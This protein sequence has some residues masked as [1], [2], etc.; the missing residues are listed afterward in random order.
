MAVDPALAFSKNLIESYIRFKLA[1]RQYDLFERREKR[2]S[3][4]LQANQRFKQEGRRIETEQFQQ[5]F[6]QRERLARTT[7]APVFSPGQLEGTSQTSGID[8]VVRSELANIPVERSDWLGWG[9]GT[10]RIKASD[11]KKAK[12]N[13]ERT[14]GITMGGEGK[15][16][17]IEFQYQR[18]LDAIL[19][20]EGGKRTVEIIEEQ[21]AFPSRQSEEDLSQLSEEELRRIIEGGQ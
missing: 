7:A 4:Q 20:P 14:L 5:T 11:I 19:N 18:Q 9:K 21:P 1:G 15:G 3:E 10:D 2:Y 13:I 6:E 8:D 17:Q 12:R 16:G